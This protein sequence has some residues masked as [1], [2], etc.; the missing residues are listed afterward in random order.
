MLTYK[1]M[2]PLRLLVYATGVIGWASSV[3]PSTR[4][5]LAMLYAAATQHKQ[6]PSKRSKKGL[7]YLKQINHAVR[8][9]HALIQEVDSLRPDSGPMIRGY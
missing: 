3:M 8:W 5:W 1:G 4:P 7:V 6:G 9:L 2:I